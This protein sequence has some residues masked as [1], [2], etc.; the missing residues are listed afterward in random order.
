MCVLLLILFSLNYLYLSKLSFINFL[1]VTWKLKS[2]VYDYI[3]LNNVVI[4]VVCLLGTWP[5]L[6]S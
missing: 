6:S 2:G 3:A 1:S 5:L 4:T